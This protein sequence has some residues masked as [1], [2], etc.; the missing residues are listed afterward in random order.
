M[1]LV[2]IGWRSIKNYFRY[3]KQVINRYPVRTGFTNSYNHV[4]IR[5]LLR[6]GMRIGL[7]FGYPAIIAR[8]KFTGVLPAATFPGFPVSVLTIW[9]SNVR[10]RLAGGTYRVMGNEH[11]KKGVSFR[12][13]SLFSFQNIPCTKSDRRD[14]D[15]DNRKRLRT[16]GKPD[17]PRD[18]GHLPFRG[19]TVSIVR[20]DPDPDK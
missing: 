1:V 18:G 10:F 2:L 7:Y 15:N 17:R 14:Y 11:G 4:T 12:F 20:A 9:I 16:D 6:S 3:E 8:G 5:G 13:S 19:I